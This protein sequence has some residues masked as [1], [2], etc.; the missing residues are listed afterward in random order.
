M[1]R[2]N[3]ARKSITSSNCCYI[4]KV[5]KSN[6]AYNTHTRESNTTETLTH[7]LT[8]HKWMNKNIKREKKNLIV[9]SF[10]WIT[11]RRYSHN[12]VHRIYNIC[13]ART[14]QWYCELRLR[15][16]SVSIPIIVSLE[17]KIILFI[18]PFAVF[19]IYYSLGSQFVCSIRLSRLVWWSLQFVENK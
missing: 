8:D 4:E 12:V 18:L 3:K 2:K 16:F 7:K 1:Y 14:V 13:C 10:G 6:T 5:K 17:K 19:F 9:M 11:E 15:Y